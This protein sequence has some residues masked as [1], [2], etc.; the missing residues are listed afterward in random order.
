[1]LE[2]LDNR[3]H[4]PIAPT[5][6][7]SNNKKRYSNSVISAVQQKDQRYQFENKTTPRTR[8]SF[9]KI[10]SYTQHCIS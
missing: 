5:E 10:L 7:N 4:V 3:A 8:A 2:K 9:V 6:N 1:M